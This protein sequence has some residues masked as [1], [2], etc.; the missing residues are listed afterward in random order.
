MILV[1]GATGHLG[2]VLVRELLAAGKQVRALVLPGEDSAS[3]DNLPITRIEGNVLEPQSLD[4][5][6]Q[7]IETVYHLAGIVSI[8]PEKKDLMW[9]VNVDGARNVALSALKCGVSRMVHTSSIHALK[10]LPHG[11]IIDESA[12]IALDSP[13]DTYDRTKAEGTRAVL[14]IADVGLDV[15]ITCPTGV[16]GPHD[17][18]Q[19]EMGQLLLSFTRK[20]LHSLVDGAYDFVD[21]RDVCKGLMQACEKGRCAEI[22]ILS[23]AR[24]K[25]LEL[26]RLVQE[27]I[28]IHSTQLV[29]PPGFAAQAARLAQPVYRITQTIPRF[30]TYSIRTLFDNSVFSHIKAKN[31]LGYEARPLIETI[32]DTLN[33]WKVYKPSALTAY[34]QH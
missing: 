26:K 19:S 9:R 14:Q 3:I 21:V 20:R 5:A 32:C 23:G 22:Y 10:R 11:I 8:L 2:N 4:W 1:T 17:Y 18:L 33:W 25:I 7:G 16:I 34:S 29:L 24:V 15:V 30:T 31:E 6:M 13:R 28:G 12:P 27:F